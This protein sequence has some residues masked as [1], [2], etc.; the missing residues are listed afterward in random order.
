MTSQLKYPLAFRGVDLSGPQDFHSS[1]YFNYFTCFCPGNNFSFPSKNQLSLS[2]LSEMSSQ[3]VIDLCESSAD[4]AEPE[5]ESAWN[6]I[7]PASGHDQPS[8]PAAQANVKTKD[9]AYWDSSDEEEFES[10]ISRKTQQWRRK[11]KVVTPE[12]HLKASASPNDK[13]DCPSSDGGQTSRR[14]HP[15]TLF[16][17]SRNNST[18][19]PA[20]MV[21]SKTKSTNQKRHG[22]KQSAWDSDDSSSDESFTFEPAFAKKTPIVKSKGCRGTT[23]SNR[24]EKKNGTIIGIES[25]DDEGGAVTQN[26]LTKGSSL[27][28]HDTTPVVSKGSKTIN[29]CANKRRRDHNGSSASIPQNVGGQI[30]QY[31]NVGPSS[32]RQYKDLRASYILALW[33]YCRTLVSASYNL[34]KLDSYCRRMKDL[35]L[36]EEFPIRSLEEF[37][38]NRDS[39]E[40]N[41]LR[42]A[43][44]SGGVKNIQIPTNHS[45]RRDGYFSVT[46]A[47]LVAMLEIVESSPRLGQV[48]LCDESQAATFCSNRDQWVY[49]SDLIPQIDK[50]LN[51]ITPSRLRRTDSD[52]NGEAFYT[53]PSTRSV[54]YKQLDQ[55]TKAEAKADMPYL[56]SHRRDKRVCYEL[57]MRGFRKATDI[58]DRR[59]PMPPGYLRTSKLY[60]DAVDPCFQGICLV[61]DN[62]EGGGASNKL[63]AMCQALDIRKVPY[64]VTKLD[65]G[66]YAFVSMDTQKYLP[67]IVE[68]KSIQDVAQSIWDGRWISQKL[69]MYQGQYVFGFDSCRMGYLIEG[70]ADSQELTDGAMGQRH[71]NV[72]RTQLD[73]EIENLQS[74]GFEVLTTK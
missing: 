74:Q 24:L 58:R 42:D 8:T 15:R 34:P 27:G 16:S 19:S 17:T 68:R 67:I 69:R 65:I 1:I 2:F 36:S 49:L 47:A 60:S 40:S 3:P 28:R 6:F 63:H 71:F 72:S 62:R 59:F 33:K 66:D 51:M 38:G 18:Q 13:E 35:A 52:D 56:K 20:P 11:S 25:S 41:A 55:L 4:E 73:S 29:P 64:V 44:E 9:E 37:I 21:A 12:D 32:G 43:L 61:V 30:L 14:K 50:R 57:T 39:V 46:E 45:P 7:P 26:A 22:P 23:N 53:N 31:P 48:D 5:V 10:I 54:E 70:H